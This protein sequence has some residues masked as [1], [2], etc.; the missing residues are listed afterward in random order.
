MKNAE[1][2]KRVL[3]HLDMVKVIAA[4]IYARI[5][6]SVDLGDLI[7]TGILGL[8][9]AAGKYD[10]GR[11]VKFSTYASLRIKGA[12]L[13]EL[14]N[15]DWASRCQRQKIK[16]MEHAFEILETQLGRPPH[17]EEMAQSLDM[18]LAEFQELRDQSEGNGIGVFRINIDE[19][20]DITDNKMLKYYI[21]ETQ[22]SPAMEFRSIH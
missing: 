19:E 12:I 3:D 8:I 9:D 22:G 15:L 17:E 13:D 10:P 5:H 14:R 7:H 21:D 6:W 11:G 1:F 20:A 18:S 4:K 2:E 16:A